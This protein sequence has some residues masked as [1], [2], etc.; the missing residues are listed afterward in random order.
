MK[1]DNNLRYIKPRLHQ[2]NMSPGNMLPSTC[3]LLP[4]TNNMLPGNMLLVRASVNAALVII[5]VIIIYQDMA[6]YKCRPAAYI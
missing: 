1:S 5:I 4:A 3:F 6:V 2:G